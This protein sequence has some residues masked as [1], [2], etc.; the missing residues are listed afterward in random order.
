MLD[1]FI[2]GDVDARY[3]VIKPSSIEVEAVEYAS[4]LQGGA[5]MLRSADIVFLAVKPQIMQDVL[6]KLS[7]YISQDTLLISIAAGIQLSSYRE[8]FPMNP[9]VRSL[10]N[11]P[12][13]VRKGMN[14]LVTDEALAP[15]DKEITETLFEALGEYIWL[16]DEANMDAASAVSASG[17]AFVFYFIEAMAKAGEAAGLS[18]EQTMQLARQTVIGAAVLAK[19]KPESSAAELRGQVTSAKGMTAAGLEALMDGRFD[20]VLKETIARAAARSRTLAKEA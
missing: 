3:G 5:E 16:K 4:S 10:P 17:P 14:I 9:F 12:S 20:N 2:A 7:T 13:A 1:G 11:T 18:S 19:T 6:E 15:S 8:H